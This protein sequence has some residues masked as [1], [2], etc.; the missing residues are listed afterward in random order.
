[1]DLGKPRI[2]RFVRHHDGTERRWLWQLFGPDG[3][4][5][6]T[7]QVHE[8]YGKA[9]ADALGHGFKPTKERYSIDL[10]HGRVHFPPGRD[11]EFEVPERRSGART[12]AQPRPQADGEDKDDAR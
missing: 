10:P 7:S 12:V 4:L 11:P 2:W 5:T 9:L 1:M 8:S 6:R 3:T